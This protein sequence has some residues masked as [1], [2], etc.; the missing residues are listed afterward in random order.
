LVSSS[1]EMS[2]S[3]RQSGGQPCFLFPMSGAVAISR[4]NG[5]LSCAK[6]GVLQHEKVMGS[7]GFF[8]F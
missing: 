3:A 6:F 8:F 5:Q 2:G 4:K 1:S 7:H